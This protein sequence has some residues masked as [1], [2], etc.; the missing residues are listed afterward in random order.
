MRPCQPL[1]F[2]LGHSLTSTPTRTEHV[3]FPGDGDL[4]PRREPAARDRVLPARGPRGA[5][6]AR[7]HA[8]DDRD[9]PGGRRPRGRRRGRHLLERGPARAP[10]GGPDAPAGREPHARQLLAAPRAPGALFPRARDAS[11]SATTGAGPTRAPRS[12]SPSARRPLAGEAAR[13]RAA[14]RDVRRLHADRAAPPRRTR[15]R[16]LLE[17]YPSLRFKLDPTSEWDEALVAALGETGAVDTVDL[18]GA[19]KG[20]PVDQAGD[21]SSTAWS[22]RASRPPGSRIPT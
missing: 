1:P 10:G 6:V 9:P 12:T 19:Y 16:C 14:A 4:R 17:R 15:C 7:L 21:P 18:K 20:T 22:P 2:G 5:G 8:P 11:P 3:P 13:P